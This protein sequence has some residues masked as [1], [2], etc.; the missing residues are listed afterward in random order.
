LCPPEA[1]PPPPPPPDRYNDCVLD[2]ADSCRDVPGPSVPVPKKN[3]CP[4]ARVEGGQVK[5]TEQVKFKT[6]SAEIL[7]ESDLVLRA[8]ADILKGHPEITKVRVEGHTDNKGAAAYNKDLSKKRATSVATWL[9]RA[10]IDK[11]RL[12]SEG[13]GLEKPI[14]DNSTEEG[15][16]NNRRVEFHIV[17]MKKPEGGDAAKPTET[18]KTQP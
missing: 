2:S 5:I 10:G 18:P 17:D 8:I 16:Q 3:G 1:P 15:R 14:D 11:K 9:I 12:T 6:A 7:P 13:F 4:L